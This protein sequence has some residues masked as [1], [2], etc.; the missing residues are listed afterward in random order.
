MKLKIATRFAGQ[1]YFWKSTDEEKF[2][3]IRKE[4]GKEWV[5]SEIKEIIKVAKDIKNIQSLKD[6][7]R[8][9]LARAEVERKKLL[10]KH[11]ELKDLLKK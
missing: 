9:V 7:R 2:Q 10:K 8:N 11:P 6:R 4:L 1:P 5:S 3:M